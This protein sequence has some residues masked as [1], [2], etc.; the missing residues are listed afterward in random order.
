M[1]IFSTVFRSSSVSVEDMVGFLLV[2]VR[3]V[4]VVVLLLILLVIGFVTAC[5]SQ[6]YAFL[7][8]FF[9]ILSTFVKWRTEN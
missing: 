5:L 8:V 1:L 6:A 4:V 9:Q 7:M 3:E 2:M